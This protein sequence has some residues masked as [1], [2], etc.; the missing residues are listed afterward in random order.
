MKILAP[1]IS[2]AEIKQLIESGADELYCGVLSKEW[3]T[4]YTNVGSINRREFALP[5][6]KS[7][8]EL[9]KSVKI[10]HSFNTPVFLTMN[11]LYT[12]EQYPSIIKE[13]K[14]AIEIGI[15]YFIIA[16]IGLLLKLKEL[17]IRT[18]IQISTGATVFN[19]KIID[20][21]R[22]FGIYKLTIPRQVTIEEVKN[23]IKKGMELDVFI[24]NTRCMNEDGFCT[25]QHG[26]NEIIH[27]YIGKFLKNIKYDYFISTMLKKMPKN[28]SQKLMQKDILGSTSACHLNY[29]VST[30]GTANKKIEKNIASHFG[31]KYLPDHCGACALY[32]FNNM[33]IN[34]V[35][36]VGRENP[37]K[38]KVK[39]VKFLK[40]LL[41]NLEQN[42]SRKHFYR[43][44]KKDFAKIYGYKCGV[45]QCYYTCSHPIQE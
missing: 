30:L 24:M 7:F 33:G 45:S 14:K 15:D 25:F 41:N 10:A 22:K 31:L 32:D 5:N 19:S 8:G 16:D 28:V 2:H 20:F 1:I 4:G 17:S 35:K 37:T 36:I 12:E 26:V 29:D 6:M 42:P 40:S 27:P 3:K 23:L 39:D 34:A 11:G 21:Y 13:I 44:C 18:K 9:K 38:K 43:I